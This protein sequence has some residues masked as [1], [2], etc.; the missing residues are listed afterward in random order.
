MFLVVRFRP[1]EWG[2][3]RGS[4]SCGVDGRV[5]GRSTGWVLLSG[6]LQVLLSAKKGIFFLQTWSGC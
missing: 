1:L 3:G 6:G 2:E 4:E 5:L